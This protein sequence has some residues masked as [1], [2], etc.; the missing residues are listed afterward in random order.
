MPFTVKPGDR[1][2]MAKTGRRSD[3]PPALSW[4]EVTKVGRK[5]AEL[6]PD[7][8][9]W[10]GRDDRFSLEDGHIDGGD[11]M[12]PGRVFLSEEAYHEHARA[13]AL[14]KPFREAMSRSFWNMPHDMT[15]DRIEAAAKALGVD[16]EGEEK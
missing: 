10:R 16:L 2:L 15:P 1:V 3:E 8:R 13:L 9:K 5:W 7:G 11:F 12:S 14:W 4:A 6:Q